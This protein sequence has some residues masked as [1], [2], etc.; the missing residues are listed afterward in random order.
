MNETVNHYKSEQVYTLL[1]MPLGL[2]ESGLATKQLQ[3]LSSDRV[4]CIHF[5]Q[6]FKAYYTNVLLY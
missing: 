1:Y 3:L 6:D 2:R 5:I 4:V